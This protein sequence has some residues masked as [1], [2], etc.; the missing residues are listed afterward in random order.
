MGAALVAEAALVTEEVE[1]AEEAEEALVVDEEALAVEVEVEV[2]EVVASGD[3][4]VEVAEVSKVDMGG[5]AG[6]RR[7][8]GGETWGP[9]FPTAA[10]SY[11]W[12]L[13]VWG[14]PG[15]RWWP[16]RQERKPVREECDGGTTSA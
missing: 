15:S 14:Q 2:E 4:E 10:L 6:S 7:M 8:L 3:E 13:P 1:E 16:G 12:R 5:G 11:R 9:P